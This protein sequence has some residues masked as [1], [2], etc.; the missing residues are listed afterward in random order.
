MGVVTNLIA[1]MTLQ[2]AS[3]EEIARA[4]KY[5]MVVIDAEKHNLDYKQ[6]R[7]DNDIE[8]LQKK[9][10]KKPDGRYG[11]ASTLISRA[12]AETR[13][14]EV[15]KSYRPDPETGNYIYTPTGATYVD[16]HGRTQPKLSK[17][18]Q[19]RTVSDAHELSSG[20]VMESVY[21]DYA[22]KMK[23]LASTARKEAINSKG[24]VYSPEA[25]KT[26][27][28]EVATLDAKI[29]QAKSH[30]PLERKAQLLAN[31]TVAL[32]KADNPDMTKEQIRKHTAQALGE[33]RAVLGF[34]P[35][36]DITDSEWEAIQAGAISKTKLQQVLR[37]SDQ[38]KLKARAMPKD[39][40]GL[41]E[42]QILRAKSRITAGY[43]ISEVADQ[44]GIS[45]STLQKA[46]YA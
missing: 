9:Y 10:Q 21:A 38:D 19:M 31:A 46:I 41:T 42:S 14:P 44:L 30:A 5:S 3:P 36:I 1:D 35:K 6:A 27:S 17:M 11:G 7:K 45:T 28:K 8:G 40:K 29:S 43:T 13:I 12:S 15:K 34:K 32:K 18:E 20:T 24:Q 39:H 22:N 4:V 25:A 23:T 16:K 33:A 2:K 26:Y 37:Y